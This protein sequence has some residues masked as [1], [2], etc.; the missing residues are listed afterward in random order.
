MRAPVWYCVV[1][2]IVCSAARAEAARAGR[3]RPARRG[4]PTDAP[5][6]PCAPPRK[7]EQ[8]YALYVPSSYAAELK[9][10]IVYVFDPGA[11]GMRPLEL[12]KD[13]AERHGYLVAASNNSR[14]GP[15]QVSQEA[16]AEMW[17]DTHRLALDRRSPCLL[18][19]VLRRRP[20]LGAARPD[21]SLRAGCLPG[22]GRVQHRIAALA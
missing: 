14:N 1:L 10:P 20:R 19:R 5:S 7:P 11:Q 3:R 21:L 18:R 9:W 17:D 16:A 6:P 8:S 13:A 2:A 4:V 22:R 12:M 15:W